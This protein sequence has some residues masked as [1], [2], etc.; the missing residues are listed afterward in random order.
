M[1][2]KIYIDDYCNFNDFTIDFSNDKNNNNINLSIL[3]GKNGSGKST[4]LDALFEIG[5]Y[6]LKTTY[7]EKLSPDFKYKINIGE[8]ILCSNID[9]TLQ[10]IKEKEDYLWDK[11]IRLY[12]GNTGRSG[13]KFK[14][15]GDKDKY[16]QLCIDLSFN[17][18]KWVLLAIFLSNNW[19]SYSTGE[20]NYWKDVQAL[21]LGGNPD[22]E[23]SEIIKPK[24]FWIETNRLLEFNSK[25]TNPETE[26]FKAFLKTFAIPDPEF[27]V[28]VDEG[29]RSRHFWN[30]NYNKIKDNKISVINLLSNILILQTSSVPK[31]AYDFGIGDLGSLLFWDTGFLYTKIQS[32]KKLK[33]EN[34][35]TN[36]KNCIDCIESKNKE[37]LFTDQT[38]SD[39]E[40]GFL[41]R[42]ALLM[43]IKDAKDSK[44]LIL[45]D[46][47]ETHFNEYWKTWFLYLLTEVLKGTNHDI[48]IATHSAML[49]TDAKPE[50]IH[51]LENRESGVI[52][53]P[54]PINTYGANIV[55]I[56]KSLFQMESD[57]GER[58]KKDIE[59]ALKGK[60]KK[61]LERLLKEVGPGEWRWRIRSKLKELEKRDNGVNY[62]CKLDER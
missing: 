51:R 28:F 57:I 16:D 26:Q 29:R 33:V 54:V 39:G 13:T 9:S 24:M 38:L 55:D 18:T 46:E 50:E 61:P 10:E 19:Y 52:H 4:F 11:V 12:T 35:C 42:F 15:N 5:K 62:K 3:V 48:F 32:C 43:A 37:K 36:E 25:Y 1:F 59:K 6:N 44:Y 17:D 20:R 14:L 58:S 21:I 40:L 41:T 56:G 47:P 53:Y 27:S 2:S 8:E 7:K 31:E 34:A 60:D 49:V 30:V 23:C 22:N 45:L